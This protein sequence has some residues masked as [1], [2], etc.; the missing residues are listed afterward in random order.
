MLVF[1]QTNSLA[2]Y[3]FETVRWYILCILTKC[4]IMY[5]YQ[6]HF[7]HFGKLVKKIIWQP[8]SPMLPRVGQRDVQAHG[9]PVGGVIGGAALRAERTLV[10]VIELEKRIAVLV[11]KL[12]ILYYLKYRYLHNG[13]FSCYFF[14]F[15]NK[16]Y[17]FCIT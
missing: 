13:M 5:F 1:F 6:I 11:Q 3:I 4:S 14:T 15:W 7:G 12:H 9:R 17:T 8:W 2:R 10:R 16:Y